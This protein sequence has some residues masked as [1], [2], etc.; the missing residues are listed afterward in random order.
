MRSR[1]N[2]PAIKDHIREGQI[3]TN[4][5]ILAA[6]GCGILLILL[7]LR[8]GYLQIINQAHY[9]TLSENN[10]VS[11]QPI[12]PT[13]GLIYDRNGVLL[14]QNLPSFT[15]ELV[16]EHIEDVDQT[17]EEIGKLIELRE[18]DIARFKKNRRRKRRFE[19]VP[20]RF[21]LTDEEVAKISTHQYRL[22]GVEIR[23]ELARHY[24]LGKLA[25]H[26]IGYVGRI[27][28]R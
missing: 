4:R 19:G 27:S 25:S 3:F 10:R 23:A 8:L 26:A 15:L 1:L 2:G 12:P 21:R 13:R 14:A 9:A 6:I 18:E 7:L 20:L 28:E 5:L 22:P 16:T 17:L 11:I 24:P